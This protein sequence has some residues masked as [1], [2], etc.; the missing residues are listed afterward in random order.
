VIN[1]FLRSVS[2]GVQNFFGR[3]YYLLL[4]L[5]NSSR[6]NS[7]IFSK[8]YESGIWGSD[9]SAAFS[10]LGSRGELLSSTVDAVDKLITDSK[11]T[12][13]LDI[14]CGDG[15]FA[16]ELLRKN[17]ALKRYHAIDVSKQA[18]RVAHQKTTDSRAHF[19]VMDASSAAF[20]YYD[21]VLIR[22]V[23]QHLDNET[24]QSV[25][26]NIGHC[27]SLLVVEHRPSDATAT[28]NKNIPTGA[29]TRRFKNSY[30]DLGDPP[31]RHSFTE[32]RELS[33]IEVKSVKGYLVA[34][35]FYRNADS[36]PGAAL[37]L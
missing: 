2:E 18:L 19:E 33:K 31:F 10:G 1:W 17:V 24:I 9:G 15:E 8:I 26:D 13:I 14:G 28:P 36:S 5:T 6:S 34:T 11:A 21:L 7:E 27:G 12:S 23:L 22:Q 4:R 3:V 35:Y 37:I 32:K 20:E 29:S 25:L 30:V 16:C